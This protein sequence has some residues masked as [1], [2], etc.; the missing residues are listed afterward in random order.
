MSL[1]LSTQLRSVSW[2]TIIGALAAIVHYVVAVTLE[3]HSSLRP[4]WANLS[5]FLLA[6]PVSYLGHHYLSFSANQSSHLHALPRFLVVAC[7]GFIA[8]QV[9]LLSLLYLLTLPFW[10]IL[11]GVMVLVAVGTYLLSHYWAFSRQHGS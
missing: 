10:L 6:F 11:G 9:L 4:A 2:F 1:P 7:S 8:N 3:S 5:G